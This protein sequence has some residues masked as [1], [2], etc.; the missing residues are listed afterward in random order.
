M[1]G[2]SNSRR[3]STDSD[4]ELE[5]E[6]LDLPKYK[7]RAKKADVVDALQCAVRLFHDLHKDGFVTLLHQ[8]LMGYC[9]YVLLL[10]VGYGRTVS[11]VSF[12]YH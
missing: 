8:D 9:Y 2:R 12:A 11:E 7:N 3:M 6:S 10:L 4:S 5:H 1:S